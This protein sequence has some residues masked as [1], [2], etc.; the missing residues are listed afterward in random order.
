MTLKQKIQEAINQKVV[1]SSG[2]T[3]CG[4]LTPEETE[5]VVNDWLV[6]SHQS[7]VK[8]NSESFPDDSDVTTYNKGALREVNMLLSDLS[9][10]CVD[11]SKQG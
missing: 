4:F 3:F 9:I 2:N 6:A 11:S 5:K 1:N 8:D 7:I 10:N